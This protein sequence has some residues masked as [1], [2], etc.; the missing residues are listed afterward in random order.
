MNAVT[1]GHSGLSPDRIALQKS[2]TLRWFHWLV[3]CF[4]LVLTFSAWY[5]TKS[6][7]EE[8]IAAQFEREANQVV[9][10]VLERL[11]LYEEALWSG[12]ALIRT[13]GDEIAYSQ[14][15]EY[16][17][18]IQIEKK[19]PGVN[20]IGV[21]YAIDKSA[22]PA[23]LSAQRVLRPDYRIHPE[24]TGDEYY[25]ITYIEPVKGN[26][27]AVGL[28]MAHETNRFAAAKRARDTGVAQITGPI[29][30]VQDAEQTPGFLFY[31]PFY[32]GGS[33]ASLAARRSN[34]LGMVYAPF[35]VKKLMAGVLERERRQVGIQISDG[36]DILYD[37]HLLSEPD[38]DPNPLLKK[39]V[40]LPLYG[41]TWTFHI[42]SARSFRTAAS[43]AQ[44]LTILI[45][46]LFIDS[47]LFALFIVISRAN[48][49]ALAYADAMTAEL[50]VRTRDLEESNVELERF[51]YV[52]AHDLQEPLRSASGFLQLLQRRYSDQ[53][54]EKGQHYIERTR[55]AAERMLQLIQGL[56]GYAQIGRADDKFAEVDCD[57][58]VAGLREDLSGA[59]RESGGGIIAE[60]LPVIR[61]NSSQ[62]RQ[63]FQNLLSNALKFRSDIPPEIR[64]YA[65]EKNGEWLFA[66][67]DNG[68]G[69]EKHHFERI[70]IIFQRLHA[71]TDYQGT[72]V[73]LAVCRKIVEWHGGRIWVEAELGRGATFYFTIPIVR[74][75]HD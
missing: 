50:R 4:S 5:F 44:P 32:K 65:E 75:R 20:G 7:L 18:N 42:L 17:S 33:K 1:E 37:E 12:T 49:K 11:H 25:P 6:Q 2:A 51:A 45:G 60:P 43:S 35:V 30:L 19:Y 9:E 26:E 29:V 48:R 52:T 66:V 56:L 62:V 16:A 68:I 71:R 13:L 67:A 15:Q 73:G 31:A 55:A 34:F 64:I 22:L 59:L 24:H 69:I 27:K 74:E 53:L 63:L 38:Y 58:L 47:L 10:L 39:T 61:G 41:R 8:R 14:W 46:G 70:F 40:E 54:D 3:V 57:Q 36:P 21:I 23:Y 72:G 28:D